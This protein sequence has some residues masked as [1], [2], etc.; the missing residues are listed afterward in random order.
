MRH[1]PAHPVPVQRHNEPTILLVSVCVWRR[2]ALL[3]N[4]DVHVALVEAWRE[5]PGWV[6][7]NYMIMPDHVHVFCAPDTDR[8]TDVK[9]WAQD[10]KRALGERQPA[11]AGQFQY[12][13]WDTQMRSRGH[14]CRKLEYVAE[15]PVR[16]G[17][18]ERPEDWPYRGRLNPLW[19]I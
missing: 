12:D 2:H 7:G 3:A 16:A 1:H 18:V 13:C 6:V 5:T 14:Y 9:G 4:A 11:L 19:W 10:W 15:N 8:R 17:L